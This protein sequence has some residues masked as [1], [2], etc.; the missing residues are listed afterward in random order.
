MRRFFVDPEFN[1]GGDNGRGLLVYHKMGSGKT[2]LAVA[3][4]MSLWDVYEPLVL[5]PKSLQVNFEKTVVSVVRL[6]NQGK[7][8]E[9]I[10]RLIGHAKKRFHFISTNASN[11]GQKIA[12]AKLRK[13]VI[14]V[15]GRTTSSARSSTAERTRAPSTT[16]SWASA[17]CV[18]SS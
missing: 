10:G 16:P 18:W 3:I 5:L 2:R 1:L 9:E 15:D 12:S 4:A 17:T 8:S 13:R 11:A 14:I 7:S 6:L